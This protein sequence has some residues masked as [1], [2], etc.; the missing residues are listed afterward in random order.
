MPFTTEIGNFLQTS[1]EGL[2]SAT[3]AKMPPLEISSLSSNSTIKQTPFEL[4]N[5]LD[6][7][8]HYIE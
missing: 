3:L 2:F 4:L 6:P 8:Y 1:L 7:Y 5:Y